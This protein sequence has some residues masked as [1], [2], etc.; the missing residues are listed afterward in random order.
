[1]SKRSLFK[2][3]V[4]PKK[5]K[6]KYKKKNWDTYIKENL[7]ESSIPDYNIKTK[8]ENKLIIKP[9]TSDINEENNNINIS[10]KATTAIHKLSS[11]IDINDIKEQTPINEK[12]NAQLKTKFDLEIFKPI[13]LLAQMNDKIEN[14]LNQL[15]MNSDSEKETNYMENNDND[16]FNVNKDNSNNIYSSNNKNNIPIKDLTYKTEKESNN[17]HVKSVVFENNTDNN[18][19][20]L[21]NNNIDKYIKRIMKKKLYLIIRDTKYLREINILKRIK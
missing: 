2:Q 14:D 11:K 3:I 17:D 1:M 18:F 8:K 21:I 7:L 9:Q 5:Q 19:E 6:N 15:I 13:L 10:G 20:F 12:L 4:Y 16:E